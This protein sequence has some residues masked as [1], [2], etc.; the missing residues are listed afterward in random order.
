[1]NI[2]FK[3]L[4]KYRTKIPKTQ[5]FV[6]LNLQNFAIPRK[7]YISGYFHLKATLILCGKLKICACN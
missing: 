4:T 1:M 5:H 3:I 6:D 2:I 7:T